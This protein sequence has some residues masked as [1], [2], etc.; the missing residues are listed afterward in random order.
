MAKSQRICQFFHNLGEGVFKMQKFD[1]Q[2]KAERLADTLNSEIDDR[3]Y[4]VSYVNE[5]DGS[6]YWIVEQEEFGG[7]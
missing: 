3:N 2:E 7:N 4:V 6:G 5:G 1:T